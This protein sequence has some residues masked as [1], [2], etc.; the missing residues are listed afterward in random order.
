MPAMALAGL[1]LGAALAG[2]WRGRAAWA[3]VAL[4]AVLCWPQALNA[5]QPESGFRLYDLPL[6]AALRLAPEADYLARHVVEYPV[7]RMVEQNTP[8]EAR[9]FS[10]GPVASAYLPRAVTVSWQSAEGE[11]MVDALRNGFHPDQI[12]RR[13]IV[14]WPEWLK[15]LRF[16]LTGAQALEWDIAEVVVQLDTAHIRPAADWTV[17]AWPNI[18][19]APLA[20]DGNYT[21]GWRTWRPVEAGMM[22]EIDFGKP[23][24]ADGVTLV[25]RLWSD[26]LPLEIWAN[27]VGGGWRLLAK[28]PP[29]GTNAA[30]IERSAATDALRRAG[31]TYIL[32]PVDGAGYGLIGMDMLTRSTDWGV[33]TVARAGGSVLFRI[34]TP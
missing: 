20:L 5:W 28:S 16:R 2:L 30:V 23:V 6:A 22:F 3:A 26:T 12:S 1:A 7:A 27:R 29:A 19:E 32:A 18:W 13:G 11:C 33:E 14:W 21:T 9:V 17:R 25:S 10:F 4:Q 15:G 24:R 34:R 31:F 8:L